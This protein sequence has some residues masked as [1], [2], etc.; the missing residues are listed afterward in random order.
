MPRIF[1]SYRRADSKGYSDNIY[2]ALVMA[3]GRDA[4]EKDIFDIPFGVDFREFLTEEITKYDIMLVV[5]GRNW[6]IVRDDYNRKMLDNPADFVRLTIEIALQNNLRVIP[7]LVDQASMPFAAELPES[8]HELCYRR[9]I[10]IQSGTAFNRD[11]QRL[12]DGLKKLDTQML[13]KEQTAVPPPPKPATTIQPPQPVEQAPTPEPETSPKPVEPVLIFEEPEPEPEVKAPEEPKFGVALILP[14]PFAWCEIPAGMV[15]VKA[16]VLEGQKMVY[17][18]RF[19]IAKYPITNAQFEVFLTHPQGYANPEWW[20]FHTA[21]LQWRRGNPEPRATAFVGDHLPRTN[22]SWY[23]AIAF[24]RWLTAMVRQDDAEHGLITLPTEAQWQ[25][26]AQ[27]DDVRSYPWGDKFKPNLCNYNTQRPLP[28]TQFPDG[29]SP[30]GVMD[31]FGNVYEWC[32]LDDDT[33]R[34]DIFV[35]DARKR[36]AL[37]GGSWQ[38]KADELGMDTKVLLP[39]DF[40]NGSSG[41]RIVRI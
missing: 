1:I 18:E 40:W 30:Y 34:M 23:E 19:Q 8:L 12:I 4:V 26:A 2:D 3:F 35:N 13:K 33:P 39:S 16:G 15:S 7:V 11:V 20:D 29:A 37:R 9:A 22:V 24:T 27:G 38:S 17:V 36:R 14:E 6:A 10:E 31:M 25:R 28:V 32:L 5:I 41:F 21:A